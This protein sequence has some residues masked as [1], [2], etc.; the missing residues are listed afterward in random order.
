M[1]WLGF[2]DK[3]WCNYGCGMRP[4]LNKAWSMGQCGSITIN[5]GKFVTQKL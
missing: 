2:Y 1:T 5:Y 3:D 4:N